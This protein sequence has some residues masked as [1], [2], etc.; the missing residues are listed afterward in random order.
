MRAV[1]PPAS[2]WFSTLGYYALFVC[3]GLSTAILGPTLP[4]LAERTGSSVA[5]MGALFV[6]GPAGYTLGTLLGSRLFDRVPGHALLGA[7]ELFAAGCLFSF[8]LLRS[9]PLLLAIAFCRG[10]AEGLVNTGGNTLL[11][12]THGEKAS[13]FMNG[14]HFCFGLGAFVAPLLVARFAPS[15]GGFRFAY[16]AVAAFAALS[17]LFMLTLRHEPDPREHARTATTAHPRAGAGAYALIGMAAVFLF[18]YVGAEI[19]FGSWL[20]TYALSLGLASAAGAAYLSSAVWF[21]FT[22]GRA[23]SIPVALRFTPRQVIPTAIAA[24]LALSGLLCLLPPNPGLLWAV[25]MGLG[26]FM[27]PL[28]P[29]G[30]TLAGQVIAMTASASGLVLL[31]DSLGVMVLPSLTGK[32]MEWTGPEGLSRSLPLLVLGALAVCLLAFLS[33]LGLA[34]RLG[35][36]NLADGGRRSFAH[37]REEEL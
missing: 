32:V 15:Q 19:S 37:G 2:K 27:A 6:C 25:A 24:C 31:G 26:F 13:P 36:P 16:F 21:S 23:V 5:S 22:V 3:I 28:W 7:A 14:L 34:R 20:Y 17:G 35:R 30:Y 1:R 4:D 12:W 18:A 8:P 33:L 29:S 9:F 11:L 10:V